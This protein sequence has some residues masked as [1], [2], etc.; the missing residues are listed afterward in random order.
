MAPS[1]RRAENTLTEQQ[2]YEL[3]FTTE[4]GRS[5]TELNPWS[6]APLPGTAAVAF[7]YVSGG[8][9]VP[10]G[11]TED[12]PTRLRSLNNWYEKAAKRRQTQFY[13]CQIGRAS[14]RERVLRLV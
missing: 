13:F 8:P 10:P 14:C 6:N 5:V 2:K 4:V 9:M 11:V 7:K 3:Q 12:L 1:H